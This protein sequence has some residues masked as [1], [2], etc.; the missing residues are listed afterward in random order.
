[1]IFLSVFVKS[2]VNLWE[3]LPQNLNF[4]KRV[5]HR[6]SI[7]DGT[8]FKVG[9]GQIFWSQEWRVS[10][11]RRACATQG[12]VWGGMCPPEKLELFW[13]CGLKWSDLVH[14]F[15]SCETIFNSMFIEVF[16]NF[17]T[18]WSKKWRGQAPPI[19]KVEGPLAPLAPRF[20]HLC[21]WEFY[22][23]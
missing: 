6:L 15:S 20:R 2:R 1:M 9:G 16:F 18:G 11:S 7:G 17:R 5:L 13:K 21:V 8:I 3:N 19:W 12:G 23:F 22:S 14:Y 10:A 4:G